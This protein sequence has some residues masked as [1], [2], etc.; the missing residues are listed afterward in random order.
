MSAESDV[1]LSI[2][3]QYFNAGH[4]VDMIVDIFSTFHNVKMSVRT[5]ETRLKEVY[6]DGVT[7]PHYLR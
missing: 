3:K 6:L 1:K 7:T 5:L 4:T 2:I